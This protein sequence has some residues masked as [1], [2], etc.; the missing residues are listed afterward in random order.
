MSKGQNYNKKIYVEVSKNQVNYEEITTILTVD[1]VIL[2]SMGKRINDGITIKAGDIEIDTLNSEV[3][4]KNIPNEN[5][6]ISVEKEGYKTASADLI[7]DAVRQKH[8]FVLEEEDSDKDSTVISY[9]IAEEETPG[10]DNPETPGDNLLLQFTGSTFSMNKSSKG[11]IGEDIVIKWGDGSTTNYVDKNSLNHTYDE[12][13]D[14]TITITGAT[15]LQEWCFIGVS[16]LKSVIIPENVT[17]I[18]PHCFQSCTNL[19]SI[20]IPESITSLGFSCFQGCKNLNSINLPESITTLGDYCFMGSGLTSINIPESVTS[21]GVGCFM[22]CYS[23][24]NINIP[25]G[26]TSIGESCFSSCTGL[27]NI[28]IPESITT[29]GSSCFDYSGLTEINFYWTTSPVM[30]DQYWISECS[31]SLKFTI[32]N[33]TTQAYIDAGYPSNKLV[34]RSG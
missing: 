2:N 7:L 34:E 28:S 21:L 19:N 9:P 29:I 16:G 33:G 32:P 18:E 20:N 27:T 11:L 26:V 12:E 4:I 25:E 8:T 17:S 24:T 1:I 23:L 3:L 14:Y 10:D 5:L 31:S 6:S 15:Q 30:Y 22:D 13:G